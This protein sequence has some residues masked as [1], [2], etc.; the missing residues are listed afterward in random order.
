[1]PGIGETAVWTALEPLVRP[2]AEGSSVN[3]STDTGSAG[4]QRVR[5]FS[6]STSSR[7]LQGDLGT[8]QTDGQLVCD[9][10]TP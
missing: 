2:G 1:M 5:L 7:D 9:Q 3:F 6:L 10:T 8:H 4:S